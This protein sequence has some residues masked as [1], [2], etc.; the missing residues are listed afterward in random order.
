MCCFH[1]AL[2][3]SALADSQAVLPISSSSVSPNTA[4]ESPTIEVMRNRSSVSRSSHPENYRPTGRRVPF[5]SPNNPAA[6]RR[7]RQYAPAG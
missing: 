5:P 2:D 7:R 1:S 3:R 6:P 4:R